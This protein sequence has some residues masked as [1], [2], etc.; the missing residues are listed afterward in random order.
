MEDSSD[1]EEES[2]RVI[3]FIGDEDDESSEYFGQ[4]DLEAEKCEYEELDSDLE[5][6]R[7]AMRI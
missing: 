2:Q 7:I 3:D 4:L 5:Q 6:I 1:D